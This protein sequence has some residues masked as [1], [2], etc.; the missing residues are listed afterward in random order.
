M[1]VAGEGASGTAAVDTA[2]PAELT[3]SDPNATE[4]LLETRITSPVER[5]VHRARLADFNVRLAVGVAY[6]WT[7]AVI[8]DGARRSRDI[9]ASGTI[10][11]I[12]PSG[13][14]GPKLAAARG[15]D[16]ASVYA[17]AG[18]WY[19]A[20]EAVSDLIERSAGDADLRRYRAQLLSQAG[21]PH[22][23]E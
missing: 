23:D 14:L 22:I 12:D 3:I 5:G 18:I 11:R 16:L 8:P 7:V 13:D 9:L 1:L 17:Q 2:L 19:D 4:P 20:L 21:L 6:Q 10:E 15:E